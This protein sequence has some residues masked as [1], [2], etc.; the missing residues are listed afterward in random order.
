[1]YFGDSCEKKDIQ[2]PRNKKKEQMAFFGINS[3][4]VF[5]MLKKTCN[6]KKWKSRFFNWALAT[7]LVF[8]AFPENAIAEETTVNAVQEADETTAAA[9]TELTTGTPENLS[10]ETA[11]PDDSDDTVD[12]TEDVTEEEPGEELIEAID[13]TELDRTTASEEASPSTVSAAYIDENGT[14]QTVTATVI[15][16]DS[17]ELSSG[18]YVVNSE[19]VDIGVNS[20]GIDNRITVSGDVKLILADGCTLNAND[21]ITVL[22]GNSFTVY[23]QSGGTGALN[24]LGVGCGDNP[25]GIGSSKANEKA[26]T[27]T[28]V[29]GKIYATGGWGAAGI[30]GSWNT[31]ADK[32]VILGGDVTAI[33]VS[34]GGTAIGGG[35]Y[36]ED[37]DITISGGTVH[38]EYSTYRPAEYAIGTYEGKGTCTFST[39]D[40][41]SA[42]IYAKSIK[43]I[44]STSSS[45][46]LYANDNDGTVYGNPTL[47]TNLTVGDGETLTIPKGKSLTIAEGVTLT[48]SGGT[49]TNKGTVYV[50]GSISDSVEGDVRYKINI[51][52]GTASVDGSTVSYAGEGSEVTL[53]ATDIDEGESVRWIV[54]GEY[55]SGNTFTMTAKVTSVEVHRH[56]VVEDDDKA[57]E[58]TCT[59]DG[60]TQGTHCSVCGDV[61]SAKEIIPATGHDFSGAWTVIK[62]ATATTDGK[63][64]TLCRNGCETKTIKVIP[65][66]GTTDGDSTAGTL[67]VETEIAVDAPIERATI[68]NSKSD[69]TDSGIFTEE[70]KSAVENGDDAKVYIQISALDTSTVSLVDLSKI[71]TEA[72]AELG[73]SVTIEYMDISLFKQVGTEAAETIH[74]PGTDIEVTFDIPSEM[75]N[76]NT[77]EVRKYR[78]LR[79]HDGEVTVISGKFNAD[80]H[81]F[82]FKTDKFSTYAIAYED[83]E[84][85]I[86]LGNTSVTQT[87]RGIGGTIQLNPVV[88]P[89][90]DADQTLTYTSSDEKV[91]TVDALGKVTAVG[92]G[93]AVITITTADGA[94]SKT[95]TVN[96]ESVTE[97]ASTEAASTEAASTEAAGTEAAGTE[98]ASTE[99]AGTEVASTE[100]AST[101]TVSS[102]AASAEVVSPEAASTEVTSTNSPK[103]GDWSPVY[104]AFVCMLISG[105][106]L[107][108]AEKKKK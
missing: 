72:K 83:V 48:Q 7:A 89:V 94:V 67:S 51:T 78:I 73:T 103:T 66:T 57:V 86:D 91:A 108:I 69:L 55:I 13:D 14:Q 16:E 79:L 46:I 41:G 12:T 22:T 93:T 61:V 35:C 1:M 88:T 6:K 74:N 64:E 30:G 101:E 44:S 84:K 34:G 31:S 49:I 27:I 10:E 21:G 63:K 75:L 20:D 39:G 90:T 80:R 77:K 106:A 99:A 28:I 97:A 52:G 70:E 8:T 5:F 87:I 96:V 25:S 82:T 24:A 59:T 104:L 3:K 68:D 50:A 47:K 18:W 17:T 19:T 29:G 45:C 56:T 100:A 95:V 76:E 102:E 54:D 62:A 81:E 32:I 65:A 23:A 107:V 4:E 37:G 92:N 98:V 38:A 58:E 71:V 11:E 15:T 33:N 60:N 53:T 36:S 43:G 105:I 26:G 40:N 2:S 9:T 85:D 42:I